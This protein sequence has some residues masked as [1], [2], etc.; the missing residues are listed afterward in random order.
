[1]RFPMQTN[2]RY[3]RSVASMLRWTLSEQNRRHIDD[4]AL[5][6][7]TCLELPDLSLSLQ[8]RTPLARLVDGTIA[9][10]SSQ[11]Y[12]AFP[13]FGLPRMLLPSQT[14]RGERQALLRPRTEVDWRKSAVGEAFVHSDRLVAAFSHRILAEPRAISDFARALRHYGSGRTAIFRS[15]DRLSIRTFDD[16]GNLEAIIKYV[17]RPIDRELTRN[18]FDRLRELRKIGTLSQSIPV[19]LGF[20]EDS[21]SSGLV[22][23]PLAG[24]PA[25]AKLTEPILDFLVRCEIGAEIAFESSEHI[26]TLRDTVHTSPH[27]TDDDRAI[28]ERALGLLRGHQVPRTFTHGDFTPWNIVISQGRPSVFDWEYS[29]SDGVPEWDRLF[30]ILQSGVHLANWGQNQILREVAE[31]SSIGSTHFDERQ[32][33]AL[34]SLVLTQILL[35]ARPNERSTSISEV[36][37]ALIIA[38]EL[39]IR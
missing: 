8:V 20:V 32:I 22:T 13:R 29:T 15:Y 7:P 27:S 11:T 33:R 17:D 5:G 30:F 39:L 37:D 34:A 12:E 2:T 25:P 19:P 6:D 31:L 21:T 14:Q 3:L 4:A 9:E 24:D 28:F 35:R 23:T 36:R 1:M 18:E 10:N 26:R 16:D 38:S